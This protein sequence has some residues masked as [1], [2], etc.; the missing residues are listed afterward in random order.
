M[1]KLKVACTERDQKV[2]SDDCIEF[3]LDPELDRTDAVK[4]VVNPNGV[5]MDFLRDTSGDA[6]DVTW[7]ATVKTT[8]EKDRYFMEISI[9]FKDMGLKYK[10]GVQIGFNAF[11]M[12]QGNGKTFESVTWIGECNGIASLGKVT[13]E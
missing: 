13:L 9:P 5:F 1:D 11:R 12:R 8:K 4:F 10:A 6:G 3:Y 7:N 2:Y